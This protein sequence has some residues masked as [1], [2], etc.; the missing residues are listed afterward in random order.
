MVFSRLGLDGLWLQLQ[1]Y[2]RSPLWVKL[3]IESCCLVWLDA[4]WRAFA[5]SLTCVR[6][7]TSAADLMVK[8]PFSSGVLMPAE[9]DSNLAGR[10]R[11]VAVLVTRMVLRLLFILLLKLRLLRLL[12]LA[13]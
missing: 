3:R 7:I 10:A 6:V 9:I 4:G 11:L 2:S 5:N 13:R 8:R 12:L 1:G